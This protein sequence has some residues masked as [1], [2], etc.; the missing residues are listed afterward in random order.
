MDFSFLKTKYLFFWSVVASESTSK[1][2]VLHTK[3]VHQRRRRAIERCDG[4]CKRNSAVAGLDL[5][6]DYLKSLSSY[7]TSAVS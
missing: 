6:C 7:R 4:V 2:L 5:S 3:A 1:D